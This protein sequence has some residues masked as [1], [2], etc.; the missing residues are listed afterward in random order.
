MHCAFL[1]SLLR[2]GCLT[3]SE[4]VSAEATEDPCFLPPALSSP[5]SVLPPYGA[6]H[7]TMFYELLLFSGA[8]LHTQLLSSDV[9]TNSFDVFA[10]PGV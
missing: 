10:S 8:S 1:I 4:W 6:E 9:L 7:C 2:S 5:F 3:F